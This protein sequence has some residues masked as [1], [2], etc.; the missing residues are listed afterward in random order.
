MSHLA[1]TSYQRV[2]HLSVE[3]TA[4]A[5]EAGRDPEHGAAQDLAREAAHNLSRICSGSGS[6]ALARH[7]VRSMPV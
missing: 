6:K 5:R 1:V 7:I 3:R 4:A 2:L